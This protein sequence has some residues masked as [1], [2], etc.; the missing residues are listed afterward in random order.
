[1]LYFLNQ[2]QL[3]HTLFPLGVYTKAEVREI[4]QNLGFINA[5]KHD[6]Q[7]ICFIPDGDYG[8]FMETYT[9]HTYQ[10]GD[11]LDQKGNVIGKHRGA[12]RYTIGQ[13][14]GL[15]VAVG[16]RI[17]VTSKNMDNNTVTLGSNDDLFAL[18]LKAQTIFL[19]EPL[20]AEGKAF[21]A[22]VRYRQIEQ[23][24][25]AYP[26]VNGVF[27]VVFSRP[28]RAITAGQSVVLYDGDKVYGGGTIL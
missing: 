3:T 20:P 9:G 27:R 15:G 1:M 22:K 2:E 14:R 23:H 8:A 4:A 28:Q 13:R 19:Q 10:A 17:Y 5:K 16:Q 6:S 7:D 18:E 21:K 12:V 24:C 25:Y 26:D 11:F